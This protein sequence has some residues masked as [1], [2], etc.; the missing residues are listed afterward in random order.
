MKALPWKIYESLRYPFQQTGPNGFDKCVCLTYIIEPFGQKKNPAGYPK[1]MLPIFSIELGRC[2]GHV[3]S[4]PVDRPSRVP[5]IRN[6]PPSTSWAFAKPV[7]WLMDTSGCRLL[8]L[9]GVITFSSVTS[10]PPWRLKGRSISHQSD[11]IRTKSIT[12]LPSFRSSPSV[13]SRSPWSWNLDYNIHPNWTLFSPRVR[14]V[15]QPLDSSVEFYLEW[16][17]FYFFAGVRHHCWK[18]F[19]LKK[20][21][22]PSE[23]TPRRCD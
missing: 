8:Q 23:T 9:G 15:I 18:S 14:L 17:F 12:R 7:F 21:Q 2:D 4:L 3:D 16:L 19:W 10:P 1:I 11:Q 22:G 13:V 5:S 6:R 20:T